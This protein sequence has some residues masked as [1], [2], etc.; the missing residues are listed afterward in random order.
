MAWLTSTRRRCG[1]MTF[2][3][4]DSLDAQGNP[5]LLYRADRV[6]CQRG[7]SSRRL[8]GRLCTMVAMSLTPRRPVLLVQL[9]IPPLGPAPIRGNVPLAAAYLKLFAEGKGLNTVYDIDLLP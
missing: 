9:P 5:S 3:A 4:G 7:A 2:S 8:F 6:A 1:G